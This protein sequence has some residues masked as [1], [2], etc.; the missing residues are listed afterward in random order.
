MYAGFHNASSDEESFI[1]CSSSF[2]FCFSH[3]KYAL[4]RPC[5][6]F[7]LT[8]SHLHSP[9]LLR[10]NWYYILCVPLCTSW[11]PIFMFP[12]TDLFAVINRFS[13]CPLWILFH[14]SF[15]NLALSYCHK[16]GSVLDWLNVMSVLSFYTDVNECDNNPCSQECANIYGS[17]QCYCRQGYQLAEDGHSCKGNPLTSLLWYEFSNGLVLFSHGP[18]VSIIGFFPRYRWV[19]TKCRYSVHFS[20]S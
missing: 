13:S 12:D 1:S 18:D 10:K 11:T 19:C 17:Y 9:V 15:N 4:H 5:V 8:C 7:G 3:Y 2:L 6:A 16:Y 20:V 14:F